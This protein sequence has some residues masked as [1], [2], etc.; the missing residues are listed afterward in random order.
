MSAVLQRWQRAGKVLTALV[1]VPTA[2]HALAFVHLY[3]VLHPWV[4]ASD[5]LY[6]NAPMNARILIEKWDHPLPLDRTNIDRLWNRNRYDLRVFDPVAVPDDESKINDILAAVSESD[7][8]IISSN[9]NYGP[10]GMLTATYPL[11]S[12]YYRAL[13][14][15]DLGYDLVEGVTRYPRLGGTAMRSD[16]F[17]Q[18]G[19]PWPRGLETIKPGDLRPGFADESFTVYD[20][21]LVM[22]YH[23]SGGLSAEELR[24]KLLQR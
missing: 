10:V 20:H 17:L 4:I 16:P 11:T 5:S 12:L 2:A 6:A 24:R 15:G 21:P 14:D 9:R 7:Y 1:L 13:F 22:V 23:N 19:M 8:I 3:S 18:A